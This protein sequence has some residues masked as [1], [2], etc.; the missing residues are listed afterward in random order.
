M[1][2]SGCLCK[3]AKRCSDRHKNVIYEVRKVPLNLSG[4]FPSPVKSKG[5]SRGDR[6]A[7][8]C[9]RSGA[10]WVART[11]SFAQEAEVKMQY[12]KVQP[13]LLRVWSCFQRSAASGIR[14]VW[15]CASSP[16]TECPLQRFKAL[17]CCKQDPPAAAQPSLAKVHL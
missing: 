4:G 10:S 2:L 7:L 9:Q 5:W 11:K 12:V 1:F 8:A 6:T 15:K 13:V 16:F 3:Y 17:T 14:P